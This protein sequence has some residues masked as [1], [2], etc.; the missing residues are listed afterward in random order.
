MQKP[1]LE[2]YEDAHAAFMRGD[3][4]NQ[5]DE[6][7]LIHLSGLANQNNINTGTQHRDVIRGLTVNNILLKRH[8][9]RLQGHITALNGQNSRT[10]RFVIALTIASLLGSGVQ[11]WY[12]YRADTKV[13]QE[14]TKVSSPAVA[15][16]KPAL[17]TEG[18]ASSAALQAPLKS[19][20][21]PRN[22]GN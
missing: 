22:H 13:E 5:S 15:P 8:L 6:Q 2:R 9:D 11:V 12:A 19:N 21:R 17:A 4:E 1:I 14:G 18:I 7:L 20:V 3:I 16:P 10:Q